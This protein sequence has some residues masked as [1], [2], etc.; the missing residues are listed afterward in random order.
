MIPRACIGGSGPCADG[1]RA[2]PGTSRCR[3]HSSKSG[4]G[5]YA[6]KHPERAAFYRSGAWRE[7]RARHL[8]ANSACVACGQP[9]NHAD[10]IVSIALGGRQDGQLQ[11]MCRK[12]HHEKTVRD[13]HE[14]AKRAAARRK[15]RG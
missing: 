13:S 10:H 8:A 7:M 3:N 12:H 1:G 15:A 9:A 14:A 11:S 6:L 5:K 2:L 4:W